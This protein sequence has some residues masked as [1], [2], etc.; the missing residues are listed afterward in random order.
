MPDLALDKQIK[1]KEVNLAIKRMMKGKAAGIDK[2]V[3]G[4]LK[5]GGRKLK[6]AI[7][8]ILSLCFN[9]EQ[10][11]DDWELGLIVPI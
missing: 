9:L 5:F 8:M 11:P 1:R 3:V 2:F 4:L 6:E 7:F 10:I